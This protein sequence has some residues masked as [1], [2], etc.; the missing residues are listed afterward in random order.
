ML[1]LWCM[2][3]LL[4]HLLNLLEDQLMLDLDLADL[5]EILQGPAAG[6]AVV[7]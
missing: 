7:Q 3:C 2:V 1:V 4:K 5:L 6:D